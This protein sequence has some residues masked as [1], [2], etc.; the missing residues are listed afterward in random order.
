MA[1]PTA[2]PFLKWAGGKAQLL[3]AFTRR[4]PQGLH[5]GTLPIFV[6]PFMGGG[7]V[8]FHFNSIFRFK[9]C[10]IFDINEEL[11]LAYSVVKNDVRG[12]IDYLAG[13]SDGY[14][15]KSDAGRKDFYYAMRDTFNRTKGA[16][17][18]RQYSEDWIERAGQFIFLNR[19]CFNGLYRVNSRGGFNVPFGRYQNP[20]ILHEDVLRADAELLR[21]TT[22]H[23]GDFMQS[24]PYISE[25]TFV[26]FDPPYRPL[27]RTSSFTQYAKEGFTDEEQRRLAAYYARCNAR[28]A[29]LML[30]NSDP[31]NVDPDDEFFDDLYA[32]YH[33]D[34]VPAR[35][36]INCDGTGRGEIYEIIVT[37]YDPHAPKER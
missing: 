16:V 7:A 27:N 18:F 11:V 5:E 37:N 8:Y 15:S 3:D 14:L 13:I 34:R 6:E 9:E 31:K 28:G 4:V 12:L 25:E 10:H 22:I 33:I 17:N 36:M 19:T 30:S 24:E 2:R 1:T 29:R 23:L 32:G 21:N 26:Y 20:T 35:R